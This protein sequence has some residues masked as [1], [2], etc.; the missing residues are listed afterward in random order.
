MNRIIII[1]IITWIGIQSTA[2]SQGDLL[3]TPKRVVFE[4]NKQKEELFISNIGKDSAIYSISFL[5]YN[6]KEDGSFQ[7]IEN[8]SK[9]LRFADPYLRVFPRKVMLAPGESQTIRMQLRRNASMASGEY[10]SH[11]YFRAEKENNPLGFE[12]PKDKSIMSIQ[13]TPIYG[14]SIPAII[15]IGQ[16]QASASLSDLKLE[17]LS[18]NKKTLKLTLNRSGNCSLYGDLIAEYLPANG[19]P[20]EVGIVRGIG[21]YTSITKRYCS[22]PLNSTQQID[23]SKGKLRIRFTSPTDTPYLLYAE[24]EL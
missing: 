14:I 11:L 4:G 10:R 15:R 24:K 19:K 8:T 12:P 23:L 13:L 20:V 7:Q 5:Q 17:T 9:G 2:F 22:V 6:M 1:S 21:V 18:D 3:I 16:V